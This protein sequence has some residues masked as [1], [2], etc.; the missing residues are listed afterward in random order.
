M[1]ELKIQN[2]LRDSLENFLNSLSENQEGC[3][4]NM[5]SKRLT[6]K[7][8]KQKKLNKAIVK[9]LDSMDLIIRTHEQNKVGGIDRD[10]KYG[11]A[12]EQYFRLM[13]DHMLDAQARRTYSSCYQGLDARAQQIDLQY[14]APPVPGNASVNGR[15]R[16]MTEYKYIRESQGSTGSQKTVHGDSS[17][18]SRRGYDIG[19]HNI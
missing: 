1:T 12:V 17:R 13:A 10:N 2:F 15:N 3:K 19:A 9:S 7:E 5:T 8:K 14:P 16:P 18:G 11:N 6:L 4:D